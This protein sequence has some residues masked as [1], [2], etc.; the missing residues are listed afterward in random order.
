MGHTV[1]E[2]AV[3]LSL[4]LDGSKSVNDSRGHAAGDRVLQ[5]VARSSGASSISSTVCRFSFDSSWCQAQKSRSPR[6]H[7]RLKNSVTEREG[8]NQAV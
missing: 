8:T 6:G 2:L 7:R 1:E 4:D 3:V 5:A